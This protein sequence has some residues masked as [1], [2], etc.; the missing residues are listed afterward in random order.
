MLAGIEPKPVMAVVFPEVSEPKT[1]NTI[2]H[3]VVP[4][5]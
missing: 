4:L 2:V 1:P 3:E 5:P